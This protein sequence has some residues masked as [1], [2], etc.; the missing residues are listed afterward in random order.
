MPASSEN[1]SG[2]SDECNEIVKSEQQ[3]TTKFLDAITGFVQQSVRSPTNIPPTSIA[4]SHAVTT[5]ISMPT[6]S[7]NSGIASTSGLS[8]SGPVH[9]SINRLGHCSFIYTIF[10][11][12]YRYC[13]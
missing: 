13:N 6:I 10:L 9:L 4:N 11:L 12:Q 5:G 3:A 7:S 2:T 1:P 8:V